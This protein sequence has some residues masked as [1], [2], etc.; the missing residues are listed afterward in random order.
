[1]NL[2]P[3]CEPQLGK[4][5]IYSQIGGQTDGKSQELAL[6]WVLNLSDGKN[7]LLDIAERSR[8]K[9]SAISNAAKTLV[10]N[11]LLREDSGS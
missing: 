5:G 6:L 11:G 1:L 4:R 2:N 3:K 9:F 8:L 10:D 7:S